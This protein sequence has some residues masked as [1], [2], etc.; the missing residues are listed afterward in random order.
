MSKKKVLFVGSF[1]SNA[2][3]GSVG[4]QMYAC[5]SLVSSGLTDHVEWILLDTTGKSVPPPPAYIRGVYAIGRLIKFIFLTIT[6]RPQYSLIFSANGASV[7]EKGTMVFIS[8]LFG[9]KSIFAPRG[10]PLINE[11]KNSSF[12][13]RV[14]QA[15]IRKSDFVICQGAFWKTFFG[16][17]SPDTPSS[18]FRV[19][20]NWIDLAKYPYRLRAAAGEEHRKSVNI[21]FMGWMQKEKGIYE[22]YEALE[23]LKKPDYTINIFF[24][25]D[26]NDK[27]EL[28][29][30]CKKLGQNY[31]VAFPGWVYDGQKQQYLDDA[32]IFLLPSYAEGMP[33]SLMEA[34]ACGIPSIATTVGAI[35]DLVTDRESGMLIE[36]GNASSLAEAIDFLISHPQEREKISRNARLK[37]ET[38]HSL[39]FAVQE[40]EKIFL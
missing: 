34:M 18:K 36:P 23:M 27:N 11:V 32:D 4:G 21:L 10:G 20:S 8:K 17:L 9:V 35:P 33:N 6:K 30:L 39:S 31:N 3:D 14:V 26:G 12:V 15:I 24:L 28:M 22:I 7:F 13:K 16:Q 40:F 1:I 38:K 19:I 37:I 25:G 29:R 2:A 5:R